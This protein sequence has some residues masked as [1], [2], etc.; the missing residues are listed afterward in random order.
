M[1]GEARPTELPSAGEQVVTEV[2]SGVSDDERPLAAAAWLGE[3]HRRYNPL[4]GEWVLV[5]AGR[6]RR[7]WQGGEDRAAVERR[8]YEPTCYLCPGN[9]R[10]SGE[11][12]P[13]Y[14]TTYVFTN[15][16]PSLTPDVEARVL[17]DHPLFRAHTQPG[18]CRVLCFN[19]R[20]DLALAQ[21]PTDEIR[22]VVDLWAGQ[23]E[24]LSPTYRW[25][26]I[27][28]NRGE[29]MGASNPHPH[30]QVWASTVLPGEPAREDR[31]Q[32]DYL[33]E[34]GVPLLCEYAKLEAELASVSAAAAFGHSAQVH[35]RL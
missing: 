18:T 17:G 12:T 14:R 1:P 28:E 11:T 27:F 35:G 20:H 8:V 5:S 16:F 22:S 19:P 2:P 6:T 33:L 24:E 31:R 13:D 9:V 23:I 7:P 10:A 21:M 30:G 32:R 15:D 26:Q 34:R 4:T 3:P 25:V 29:A